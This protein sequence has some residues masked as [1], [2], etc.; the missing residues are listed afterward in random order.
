LA[1]LFRR[2]PAARSKVSPGQVVCFW[3][4]DHGAASEDRS[5]HDQAVEFVSGKFVPN[6]F[7]RTLIIM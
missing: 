5:M 6:L 4:R 2:W 7:F 3:N 1:E